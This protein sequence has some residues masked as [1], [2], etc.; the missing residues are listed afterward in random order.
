MGEITKYNQTIQDNI[1][2]V[3]MNDGELVLSKSKEG[4]SGGISMTGFYFSE[5]KL[6]VLFLKG[7]IKLDKHAHAQREFPLPKKMRATA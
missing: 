3:A 2:C 5:D 7:M 1:I 4:N 6:L